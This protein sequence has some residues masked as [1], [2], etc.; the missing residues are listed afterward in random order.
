MF[1]VMQESPDENEKLVPLTE[2]KARIRVSLG[3]IYREAAAGRLRLVKI[4]RRTFITES[5]IARFI[6]ELRP[7][8]S[9]GEAANQVVSELKKRRGG[10]G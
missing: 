7:F 6:R 8:V 3:T 10:D 5:E 1:S 2:C 4:G 9:V